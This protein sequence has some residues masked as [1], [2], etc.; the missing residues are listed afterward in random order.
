MKTAH[1]RWDA[2]QPGSVEAIAL[3]TC[4][5]HKL[6]E[7]GYGLLLA[8]LSLLRHVLIFNHAGLCMCVCV[9]VWVHEELLMSQHK[10]SMCVRG[11]CVIN[12]N[13]SRGESG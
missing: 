11:V 1:L 6:V 4:P 10:G 12:G 9:C 13:D 5:F 7:E 2:S 3:G 8:L